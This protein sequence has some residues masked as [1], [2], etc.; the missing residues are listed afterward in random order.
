M[1]LYDLIELNP[2]TK[3]QN[4]KPGQSIIVTK[5]IYSKTRKKKPES[6]NHKR[7]YTITRGKYVVKRGDTLYNIAHKH[8]MTLY[9]LI[10]L[11]PGLKAHNL[12]PGQSVIVTK[13]T[14]SKAYKKKSQNN[15]G[16]VL[17][18]GQYVVKQGDTLWSISRYLN[19][20]VS[21]IMAKN[22]LKSHNIY[23]GK[24]LKID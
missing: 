22:N 23:P 9:D 2:N 17:T 8:G 24:I 10:A 18:N 20:P 14:Y 13:K 3:A 6:R 12:K 21:E 1:T 7:N 19:V 4:L 16:G 15:I 5:K 11:N